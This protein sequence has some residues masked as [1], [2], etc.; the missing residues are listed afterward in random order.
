MKVTKSQLAQIIKEEMNS[1][2]T[3]RAAIDNLA[4]KI[5][6]LDVSI[7][8]LTSAITGEDALSIG[9]AQK[10]KGRWARPSK[11]QISVDENET[12]E[13]ENEY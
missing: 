2:P 11:T 6:D 7:D 10:A 3:L 13:L 5:D 8:Y 9:L 1:D 4:S 12:G